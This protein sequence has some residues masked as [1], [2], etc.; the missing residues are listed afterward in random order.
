MI[1]QPDLFNDIKPDTKQYRP[2]ITAQLN[3]KGVLDVDTVKGC[4]FGMNKYK[5]GGCYGECYAYKIANRYGIDFKTSV[6][7][8]PYKKAFKDVFFAVKDHNKNFYRIGTAGDPSHDWDNTV[9]I[10]KM[11][12]PTGKAPVIVTKHWISLKDSHLAQLKE[13]GATINTSTS[14]MDSNSEILHRTTQLKRI[15]AYGLKSINRVV[16]CKYG[17]SEWAIKC[18]EKQDYLLSFDRIIDTPFRPTKS[19][20]RV[21]NGDILINSDNISMHKENIHTGTCDDCPDKCGTLL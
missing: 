5:E 13:V 2:V 16:T 21:L 12:Q 10:C 9:K 7:R 11:L 6:S 18:Q 17:K 14:G 20:K 1:K 4:Y 3:G 19:N 15:G 8:L